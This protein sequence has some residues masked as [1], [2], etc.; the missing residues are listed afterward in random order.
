MESLVN[1][2]D[3]VIHLAAIIPPLSEKN[4]ELTYSVNFNGTKNIVDAIKKVNKECFLLFSSSISIYGDRLKNYNIKVNDSLTPVEHDYCAIVKKET[5]RYIE[6]SNI[7]YSIFR[8]TGIMDIPKPNPLMFHMPLATK[9]EIATA[10]DTGI[11]FSNALNYKN[12]LNKNIYNLG[13]GLLCRTTYKD[14]LKESFK[15]MGLDYKY[16]NESYFAKSGFHCGYYIDGDKL[17]N[18]INFQKDTLE[19][20]YNY[21]EKNISFIQKIITKLFSKKIVEKINNSSEFKN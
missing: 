11:A 5:E 3:A 1:G 17:N 21:M 20:Y 8:L 18:I 6:E 19:D 7:N 4:P 2:K 10:K 9:L 13:G 14:F 12:K 16:L 15:R